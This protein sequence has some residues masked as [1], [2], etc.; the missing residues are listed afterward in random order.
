MA[1]LQVNNVREAVAWEL[2]DELGVERWVCA[3]VLG[4][5]ELDR[6]YQPGWGHGQDK[7]ACT[8][9]GGRT[10]V[11]QYETICENA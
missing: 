3:P 7:D 10:N 1:W 4:E 9:K 8:T 5:R 2:V 11:W 6:G